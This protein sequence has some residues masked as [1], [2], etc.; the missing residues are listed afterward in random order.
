MVSPRRN[1]QVFSESS[2]KL[3][4]RSR[5]Q[6]PNPESVSSLLLLNKTYNYKVFHSGLGLAVV[7]RI[8]EQLGGQLRVDSTEGKGSRFSFLIP[9]ALAT[10]EVVSRQGTSSRSSGSSRAALEIY[11]SSRTSSMHSHR[12]GDDSINSL[13]QAISLHSSRESIAGNNSDSDGAVKQR[14]TPLG[15]IRHGAEDIHIQLQVPVMVH[16]A[17]TPAPL[18]RKT[19][20]S[21]SSRATRLPPRTSRNPLQDISQ[22]KLRVL[23]VE[24]SVHFQPV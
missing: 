20:L 11:G 16:S 13:I 12:S 9:L 1:W 23:I 8:V 10:D 5:S 15:A 2:N 18:L 7:A 17:D 4:L 22:T 3:N 14:L 6:A 19:S 21:S 24:V